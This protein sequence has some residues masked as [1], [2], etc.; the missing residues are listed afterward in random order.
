MS[1]HHRITPKLKCAKCN[2]D[3]L[4]WEQ[5]LQHECREGPADRGPTQERIRMAKGAF[6]D[7]VL[8]TD[9]RG[10]KVSVATVRMLDGNVLA[11]LVKAEKI[12]GDEYHA[13]ARFYQDWYLSGLAN[14]GTIDPAKDVVDGGNRA[15]H[16]SD[17]KLAA[18]T[19]YHKAV[20]AL[21]S[22][23]GMVLQ[24]CVLAEESLEDFGKRI[25]QTDN[26]RAARREAR[27]RLKDALAALDEHY[28]GPRRTRTR[29]AHTTDYR[30]EI[31]G[32]D[33]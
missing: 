12:T 4:G 27:N 11:Q 29:S 23:H 26:I 17:A 24:C 25:F 33:S 18:M 21:W 2:A 28:N 19:R 13:G 16:D 8:D 22:G 15:G 30:P 10:R 20:K 14:S 6:E 7:V 9:E 3:I 32:S 1:R 31:P 5:A